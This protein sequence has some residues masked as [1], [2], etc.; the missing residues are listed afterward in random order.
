MGKVRWVFWHTFQWGAVTEIEPRSRKFEIADPRNAYLG[1]NSLRSEMWWI[2]LWPGNKPAWC[3][4]V[5]LM[6]VPANGRRIV[7][8]SALDGVFTKLLI[9]WFLR[10]NLWPFWPFHLITDLSQSLGK[11][12]FF[13]IAPR[14]FVSS[15]ATFLEQR[16]SRS[17]DQATVSFHKAYHPNDFILMNDWHSVVLFH[18]KVHCRTG[19]NDIL[20]S[21]SLRP[22]QRVWQWITDSSIISL[23]PGFSRNDTPN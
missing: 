12:S 14:S 1:S 9:L 3:M 7:V 21:S 19:P 20:K 11:C 6:Q 5:H 17:C 13:H 2:Q 15:N 22:R 4:R 23:K 10:N 8:A 16:R 18:W